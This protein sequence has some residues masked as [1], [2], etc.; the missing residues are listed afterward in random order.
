MARHFRTSSSGWRPLSGRR[1]TLGDREERTGAR[2]AE[3]R[4][5]DPK[6][7]RAGQRAD[8]VGVCQRLPLWTVLVDSNSTR[9][10]SCVTIRPD[11]EAQMQVDA[12][13]IADITDTNRSSVRAR[14]CSRVRKSRIEISRTWPRRRGQDSVPN[15][16]ARCC[17]SSIL[18]RLGCYPR[19]PAGL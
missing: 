9:T 13:K 7:R 18:Y 8:P 6:R 17:V 14:G 11:P 2:S 15:M 19:F 16:A 3:R 5:A 12:L 4:H 10:E 1:A